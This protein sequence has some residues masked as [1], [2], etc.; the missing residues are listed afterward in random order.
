[1]QS[2]DRMQVDG[3]TLAAELRR[4]RLGRRALRSSV[5]TAP[6]TT[7][8]PGGWASLRAVPSPLV[9][10]AAMSLVNGERRLVPP[11]V[12]ITERAEGR[13]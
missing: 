5:A 10:L 7:W 9:V 12:T 1:M 8:L 3:L 13:R 11:P 2:G 6:G 4:R